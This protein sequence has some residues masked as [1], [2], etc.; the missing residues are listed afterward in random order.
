MT[1]YIARQHLGQNTVVRAF[2][3]PKSISIQH[4]NAPTLMCLEP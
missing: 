1:P 2:R 3:Q 4:P